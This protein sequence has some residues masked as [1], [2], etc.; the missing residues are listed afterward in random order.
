MSG[1]V[2]PV[3]PEEPQVYWRRRVMFGMATLATL[4]L[5]VKTFLGGDSSPA[6]AISASPSVSV[7]VAPS[8][9]ATPATTDLPVPALSP[10]AVPTV[11]AVAEGECSDADTSIAVA[12]DRQTTAVGEGLQITMTVKNI[13][14][15][16]CKRDV[17]SG[18]NE[19][20]VISGPALIWSTDHCNTSDEKNLKEF[21]PGEEWSVTVNWIGKQTAKGCKI[22]NMAT[23]GAYWAHGRNGSLN[24]DGARFEVQ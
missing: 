19:V 20:T 9:V 17:G 8:A 18:A 24:S 3:G 21:Q 16:V 1:V 14:A 4:L 7:S 13:S 23:P 2:H 10:T 12:I 6:V 22:R 11:P 5:L 15:N